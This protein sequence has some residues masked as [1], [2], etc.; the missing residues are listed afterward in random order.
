MKNHKNLCP[1][2]KKNIGK[3]KICPYCG[4]N[5]NK[6]FLS[7]RLR[8][9]LWVI[10]P[11]LIALILLCLSYFAL[12]SF[13]SFNNTTKPST[14]NESKNT[15]AELT[16]PNLVSLNF[17]KIKQTFA[18]TGEFKLL[19]LDKQFSDTIEKDCIISHNPEKGAMVQRG[20]IIAATVSL[21][22]KARALPNINGLSLSE[23]CLKLSN[24][25]FIPVKIQQH[26]NTVPENIVI[27]YQDFSAGQTI[28]YGAEIKIIVSLGQN[29]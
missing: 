18:E 21:G 3:K 22:T 25:G 9:T 14:Q 12:T 6:R 15:S 26:S 23:A 1:N 20:S 24:E 28:D 8:T 29:S 27:G 5:I 11:A 10:I 16:V 17:E 4:Q 2:C 13:G 7:P 19:L